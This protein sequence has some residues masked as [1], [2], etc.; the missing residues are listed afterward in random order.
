VPGHGRAHREGLATPS[1]VHYDAASRQAASRCHVKVQPNRAETPIASV[2][3]SAL[4]VARLSGV[5]HIPQATSQ[6]C[7]DR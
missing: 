6:I 2:S 4:E 7:E 1:R 3:V 5:V